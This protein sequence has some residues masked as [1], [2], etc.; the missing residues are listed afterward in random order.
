[1]ADAAAG[2]AAGDEAAPAGPVLT[3]RPLQAVREALLCPLCQVCA[4]VCGMQPRC[5]LL[6][7]RAAPRAS[8]AG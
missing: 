6:L 8:A 4:V 3:A 2:G 7:R 1:M 5:W